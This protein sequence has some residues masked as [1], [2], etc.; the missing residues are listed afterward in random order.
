MRTARLDLVPLTRANAADLAADMV[1]VLSGPLY[2]FTGGAPPTAAELA[3][4]YAGLAAGGSPDGSEEWWNWIIRV[5]RDAAA[6]PRDAVSRSAHAPRAAAG[7][8]APGATGR[9][10]APGGAAGTVQATIS[11]GGRSAEIAWVVGAPWQG[12]GYA[13]EA[14][15]AL[16]GWLDRRGVR[17]ITACIH[18]RHDA[19]AAVAGRAGLSPTADSRDGE[20]VWRRERQRPG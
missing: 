17:V 12:R 5:S 15:R 13:S 11:G 2:E 7:T 3:A 16:V 10:D 19:S 1:G 6:A 8:D 14:A 20:R 18:P 4:R 9:A